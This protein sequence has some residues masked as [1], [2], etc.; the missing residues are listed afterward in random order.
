MPR[1]ERF[2]LPPPRFVVLC[3]FLRIL[4]GLLR[5]DRPLRAI[6]A[7]FVR[8]LGRASFSRTNCLTSFA[9]GGLRLSAGVNALKKAAALLI[10]EPSLASMPGRVGLMHFGRLT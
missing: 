3:A 6:I 7:P 5:R 8:L 10:S 1:P 2:E 9:R 4:G